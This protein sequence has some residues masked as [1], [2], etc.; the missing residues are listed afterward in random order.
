MFWKRWMRSLPLVAL[1]GLIVSLSGCWGTESSD[2]DSDPTLE[3]QARGVEVWTLSGEPLLEIGVREGEDAYQLHRARSSARLDDGRIV[4]ANAG[5][6]ELRFFDSEGV[7]LRAVGGDGEG[8]GEFRYP[9]RVR[10]TGQ[11]SLLVWDQRL[12][13]I[14][15]FDPSGVFLG[16]ERVA[17]SAEVMFPGD[18][19]LLGRLWVDS[20]L[21]PS[22]RE[23]VRTAAERIPVP[24][25]LSTVLYLR[26]TRQGRI[27]TS[28]V[29]PPTDSPVDWTI[30]DLEGQLLARV[31]T[32]PRFGVHDIG[33]DYVLGR[34][35]DEVDV[36]FIRLYALEKPSGSPPGQGLDP[37]PP[38]VAPQARVAMTQEEDEALAPIQN[39]V[40]ILASL[41]EIHYADNYS[42]TTDVDRLFS[43]PRFGKPDGLDV[44]I[45]FA[46]QEGWMGTVTD[47]ESG[48]YCA[49]TYGTH[50][51]MGW[52]PGAVI[53]P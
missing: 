33:P 17:P 3:P 41:Q 7:F 51:P 10:K 8:P 11:D 14:S 24:D 16:S 29:R 44:T 18:E 50:V 42:Y 48:R 53:C 20:P 52:T 35:L 22:A 34:F 13:R 4:V 12:Q 31:T 43:D 37:S 40:K 47:P 21:R 26:V 32:P 36:N 25:S 6:Q 23:P 49:L 1:P 46:G 15:F 38:E 45:L 2:P 28:S 19:W 39:L 9:T 30:Y 27:W 5:S